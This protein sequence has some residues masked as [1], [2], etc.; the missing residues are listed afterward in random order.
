MTAHL[1]AASP[2]DSTGGDAAKDLLAKL[3]ESNRAFASTLERLKSLR[4]IAGKKPGGYALHETIAAARPAL[5]AALHGELGG[6]LLVVLP[7]PDAAERSFADL[8]YY[9]EDRSERIALVRSRDEALGAIESPSERSA[10]MSLLADLV[11]AEVPEVAAVAD[12]DE[13]EVGPVA[14]DVGLVDLE[15]ED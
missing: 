4:R 14:G 7:T 13:E 10:R 5:L 2:V 12:D 9:L 15:L 1:T 8:L 6:C 3:T 11:D